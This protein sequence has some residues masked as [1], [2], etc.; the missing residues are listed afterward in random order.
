[1]TARHRSV[2]I[3]PAPGG[4]PRADERGIALVLALIFSILLYILVA[5]LVVAGRMVRATGEND[6]LLARMRQQMLY[7]LTDA[8]D[9]LLQDLAGGAAGG[10]EGGGALAGAMPGGQGGAGGEGAGAAAGGEGGEGGEE[11]EEDPATKCDG[12]RDGWFEPVGHPDNDLTTYV[13]VEDE[14][15]KFNV[16]A[17]W[18]PDEK[19]AD[20]S[21]DRMVRL[22]DS[23]REDTPYDLSSSDAGS[24]VRE[25]TE[26]GRRGGTDQMPRPRL[27]SDDEKRREITPPMHLD[28]LLMLPSITEDVFFDKVVDGR[29]YLG[30]ESVLTLWTSLRVDPGNPEKNARLRAAAEARGEKP[31]AASGGEAGGQQPA[32]NAGAASSGAG[33]GNVQPGGE[34]TPPPQPEGLGIL[35]NVNTA[36][37]P[38][39]RALFPPDRIPDRVIDAILEYRNEVDEEATRKE[40]DEAGEGTTELSDF[41]D[42]R[43]GTP[44]KRKV[45]TTTADLEEVEEFAKL[46]DPQVK[47]DF[48]AAVTTQSEVFSIHLATLFKRSEENRIYVLRRARSIVL[49]VDDG[50]DGQVVPLVPFEERIGLRVMPVDLQEDMLDLVPLYNDL[51]QFAQEDRAWNPFLVDFYLPKEMRERFYTPR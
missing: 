37:R 40:Q 25:I 24:I 21:R 15:R 23:L 42:L 20:F 7:Q 32:G 28:E 9:Q 49:R 1:M 26:W 17:I 2:R 50:A 51:D 36:S 14:N 22:I 10:E 29:V 39:L 18:S 33:G 4:P 11:E 19:F 27:K 34:E 43:L 48:Q 46:A 6:A 8:E 41:G 5:E 47:A 35:V 44:Q 12:S 16:L 3:T 31:P 13:W 45:F 30:L 38:V